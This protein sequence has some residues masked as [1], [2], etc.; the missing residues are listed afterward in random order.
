MTKFR[1]CIE[2][3]QRIRSGY[4]PDKSHFRRIASLPDADDELEEIVR[5]KYKRPDYNI[6]IVTEIF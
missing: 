1:Q 4:H 5:Q 6:R 3:Y 2:I